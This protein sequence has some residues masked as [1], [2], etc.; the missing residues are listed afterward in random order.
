MRECRID[1]RREGV[2]HVA[3]GENGTVGRA[4]G[5][6]LYLAEINLDR[7][8]GVF[9]TRHIVEFKNISAGFGYFDILEGASIVFVALN[10]ERVCAYR[11][12]G[13]NPCSIGRA[14]TVIADPSGIGET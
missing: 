13:R 14:Q 3:L 11:K 7:L 9:W 2:E 10:K 8:A 4:G 1:V 5:S 12:T 6:L